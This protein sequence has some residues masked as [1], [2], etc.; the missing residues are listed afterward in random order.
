MIVFITGADGFVGSSVAE[1]FRRAG[2]EV[3]GMVYHSGDAA[4]LARS[5]I[6][7]VVGDLWKPDTYRD[8][9]RDAD[10]LIHCAA[11]Y[12]HDWA[13]SDRL[14]IETMMALSSQAAKPKTVVFTSGV[15]VYGNIKG[16]FVTEKEPP[17]ARI[18]SGGHRP[19]IETML[20]SASSVRGLVIRP[21]NVY[22][23]RG[24][25]MTGPWFEA[26]AKGKSPFVVGGGDNHWPMVHV[27]DL[28]EG[29]RLAVES[30]RS[31]I[32]HFVDGSDLTVLEAATAAARAAGYE[33]P[34]QTTPLPEA[35]RTEGAEV[36]VYTQDMRIDARKAT[37]QLGWT[38]RHSGFAD[39]ILTYFEAWKAWKV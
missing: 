5:E 13:G 12:R 32:F 17:A 15:W 36:E 35:V 27:D 14:T 29:Y 28:A 33:G 6:R 39:E 8:T 16:R 1:A 31:G 24:G 4:L 3:W 21:S 37:R 22:G 38:P 9:A 10:A 20:L 34:I 18:P 30:G 26:G 19:A 23:R 7:T 2:H 25:G 11:D